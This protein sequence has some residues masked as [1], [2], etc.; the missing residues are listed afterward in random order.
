MTRRARGRSSSAT[1]ARP[2][3]T[4]SSGCTS[5]ASA[6]DQVASQRRP[7]R[8]S[9]QHDDRRAVV[10]LV[11]DLPA[12]AHAAGRLRPRR[13]GSPGRRLARVQL[14]DLAVARTH[15]TQSI[16]P[17][18]PDARPT[19][20]MTARGPRPVAVHQHGEPVGR[21]H[22]RTRISL[23][24]ATEQRP[25]HPPSR[26]PPRCGDGRRHA[27]DR[28]AADNRRT[29]APSN[30]PKR[31]GRTVA[32]HAERPPAAHARTGAGH[33]AS[34]TTATSPAGPSA[35]APGSTR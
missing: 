10:D 35:I 26:S 2:R 5:T 33:N 4:G 30:G 17:T 23:D 11:L 20:V 15:S 21:C 18:S 32:D 27:I 16:R 24:T 13:R 3:S 1:A 22:G 9:D 7:A 31:A 28:R 14:I 6:R 25:Q 12:D 29:V 19:A 34:V 8:R